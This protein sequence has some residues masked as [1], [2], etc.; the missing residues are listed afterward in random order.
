MSELRTFRLR[1][2]QTVI[3]EL[4]IDA[5]DGDE[6][7]ALAQADLFSPRDTSEIVACYLGAWTA[8]PLPE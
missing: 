4:I 6:A 7:M 5:R 8:T 1:Y 2:Q 3:R